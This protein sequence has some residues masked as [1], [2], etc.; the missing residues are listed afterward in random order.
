M[1]KILITGGA[2]FIGSHLAEALVADG[3]EVSVIDD[4]STG[5]LANIAVLR[6]L[7]DFKFIQASVRDADALAQAMVELIR[8]EDLRTNMARRAA[9]YAESNSWERHKGAYLSLVDGL[10]D[11]SLSSHAS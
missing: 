6:K 7:L 8:D 4:L 9:D 10:C 5:S 3:K 2:G 1:Q 11:Q